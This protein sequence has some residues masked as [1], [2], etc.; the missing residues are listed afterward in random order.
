MKKL[1]IVIIGLCISYVSF[2]QDV[3]YKNDKTEIKAKVL[4]ITDSQ[5]KYKKFEMLDGPTYNISTDEVFMIIYKNGQKEIMASQKKAEPAKASPIQTPTSVNNNSIL[6]AT[7]NETQVTAIKQADTT[8]SKYRFTKTPRG[9]SWSFF[10]IGLNPQSLN[11]PG[12]I[13]PTVLFNQHTF[14]G[15]NLAIP[16]GFTL[17]YS[18][19]SSFGTDVSVG[20]IGT[21]LGVNYYLNELIK[22]PKDKASFFVGASASLITTITSGAGGDGEGSSTTNAFGFNGNFGGRYH[23]SKK[24][25]VFTQVDFSQGGAGIL[26]GISF[27]RLDGKKNKK[28]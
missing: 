17:G 12:V 14:I 7:V 5:I 20:T 27:L 21:S 6:R 25:G 9:G 10:D 11:I 1:L 26:A 3:I 15:K 18:S 16:F 28:F 23:F 19:L 24:F 22:I 2:S 4:E 8:N 13:I